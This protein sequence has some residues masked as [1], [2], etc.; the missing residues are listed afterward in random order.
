MTW[1]EFLRLVVRLQPVDLSPW[2][3]RERDQNPHTVLLYRRAQQGL[4][5]LRN[6]RRDE[7]SAKLRILSLMMA[8]VASLLVFA[9]GATVVSSIARSQA[10]FT[11]LAFAVAAVSMVVFG[12][13]L[14]FGPSPAEASRAESS[15]MALITEYR[16][17]AME[18]V[19]RLKQGA[20]SPGGKYAPLTAA[21][22]GDSVT[23]RV[24]VCI[25]EVDKIISIRAVRVFLKRMKAVFKLPGFF[26]YLALSEDALAQLYLGPAEGKNEIDSSLDHVVRIP[27]LSL[28]L[29]KNL[30]GAYLER[31]RSNSAHDQPAKTEISPKVVDVLA[32]SS[33]GI[34]RDAI[35][36]CDE[37]LANS[38][39]PS[40][41]PADVLSKIVSDEF[42][43]IAETFAWPKE[44]SEVSKQP[45]AEIA[46]YLTGL[47]D[48]DGGERERRA[49]AL[50]LIQC[51]IEPTVNGKGVA[52]PD[53][54]TPADV[55]YDL[56]YW[57]PFRKVPDL[58]KE[59]KSLRQLLDPEHDH[60]ESRAQQPVIADEPLK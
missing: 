35:R 34:P 29:C 40:D 8:L 56:G 42:A 2:L 16:Q 12:A 25:D 54:K 55:L 17:F 46:T 9:M 10:Q 47:L 14:R 1:A 39:T 31:M 26:Y 41:D 59:L 57:L 28:P 15:L 48:Q 37:F 18:I 52:T 4:T 50:L 30:V 20:L 3:E 44:R 5:F 36:R 33:F 45:I 53:G 7:R 43:V 21:P 24:L 13:V 49:I 6:R 60:H 11:I 51:M 32:L 58:L 19:E 23:P 22:D 38:D 27:P